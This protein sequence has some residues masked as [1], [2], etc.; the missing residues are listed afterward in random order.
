MYKKTL[1]GKFISYFLWTSCLRVTDL[2]HVFL[3]IY[4]FHTFGKGSS[5]ANSYPIFK[6]HPSTV[7]CNDV[8]MN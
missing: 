6:G 8:D 7:H 3:S 4:L 2:V 5:F 1:L